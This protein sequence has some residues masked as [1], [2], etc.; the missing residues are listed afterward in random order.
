MGSPIVPHPCIKLVLSIFF[1]V[2]PLI[3]VWDIII[4][5]ACSSLM[6][7]GAQNLFICL[8]NTIYHLCFLFRPFAH[9]KVGYLFSYC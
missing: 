6:I 1:A 2:V 8:F 7:Y 3:G 9:F 4:V 5:F